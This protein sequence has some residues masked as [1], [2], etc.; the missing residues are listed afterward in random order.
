MAKDLI[1]GRTRRNWSR[2]PARPAVVTLT[3]TDEVEFR[4][5]PTEMSKLADMSATK[6]KADAGDPA[7][8]RQVAKFER[9]VVSLRARAKRGDAKARRALRV[10]DESGV[11][12]RTQTFTL[13]ADSEVSNTRYRA[14][15][16]RQALKRAT[17]GGR[18]APTTKDFF[19]AKRAVDK[20]MSDSGLSL[21]LP[22]SRPERVTY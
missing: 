11:F 8:R 18:R 9:E 6:Q 22:G 13:G 15:V 7:A 21:Y 12:R 19:V 17:M 2:G 16:L 5:T 3:V 10:L 4:L 1:L 14:C 20:V